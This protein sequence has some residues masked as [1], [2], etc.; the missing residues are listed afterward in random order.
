MSD[1]RATAVITGVP[2]GSVT[3]VV[4]GTATAIA[5]PPSTMAD[6]TGTVTLTSISGST[7]VSTALTEA[8]ARAL[9]DLTGGPT[10]E[11]G[12]KPVDAVL[13][14]YSFRLPVA[15]P[16]KAPYVAGSSLTFTADGAV[17]GKYKIEVQSPGKATLNKPADISSGTSATVNFNYGP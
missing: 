1:G 14:S 11:L 10:I 16:V 3:T 4:N 2:T 17:A 7:T 6:V 13:G 8:S 12:N 15:A 5:P 9:Q